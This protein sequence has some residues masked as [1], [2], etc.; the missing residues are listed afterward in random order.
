MSTT[1]T[2][3]VVTVRVSVAIPEQ[4]VNDIIVN[5][6]DSGLNGWCGG[7]ALFD[8]HNRAIRWQNNCERIMQNSH[9]LKVVD[10]DT[11]DEY[12]LTPNRIIQGLQ[13]MASAYPA[14]FSN[15]LNDNDDAETADVLIQCCCFSGVR[16]G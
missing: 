16:Y 5:A 1:K 2:K 9:T 12:W 4:R 13:H 3:P 15:I 10:K 11:Q 14:H 8:R 6:V 7:A